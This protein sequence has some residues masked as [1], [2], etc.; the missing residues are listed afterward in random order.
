M[1]PLDIILIAALAAWF[2]LAV[3]SMK[4]KTNAQ[5]VRDVQDAKTMNAQKKE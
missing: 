4:K 1:N 3:R 5:A 2:V